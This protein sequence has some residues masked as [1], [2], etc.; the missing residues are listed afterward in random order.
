[1]VEER[2]GMRRLSTES[3][4][5]DQFYKQNRVRNLFQIVMYLLAS[6]SGLNDLFVSKTLLRMVDDLYPYSLSLSLLGHKLGK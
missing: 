1:M 2:I 5:R 6:I 3:S 4:G